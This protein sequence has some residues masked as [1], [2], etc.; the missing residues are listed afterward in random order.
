MDKEKVT[1]E[2]LAYEKTLNSEILKASRHE[3]ESLRIKSRQLWLKGGDK[4]TSYLHKQTKIEKSYNFINELKDNNNQ[5]IS[6]KDNIKNLAHQH[7]NQLYIDS[8]ETDPFSQ[9]DLLSGIHPNITEEENKE[10]EKPI[11]EN[12][13]IEAIWNLQ[14]DKSLG[15]DG[16]TINFYQAAWDI[17]KEDLRKM[18][19]W[20]R[21][22]EKF[23]GATNSTFLALIPKE[24]NP[25][26][27]E[28]FHP[29]SL[30]NTSY[31]ILAKILAARMKK[32]MAK[33][34]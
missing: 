7:F 11:T 15:H 29:I 13:I 17:I 3:E 24:K 12:E 2:I 32:I 21:K 18:L 8:G 1:Y 23:G 5:T 28:R 34:I 31:K 14:P 22:K 10:L 26:S 27:I 19:N 30:C 16:F 6:G 20:T 4:N 33:I 25:L 9:M